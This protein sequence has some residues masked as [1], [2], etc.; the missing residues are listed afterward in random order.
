M[1]Y[2]FI[3]LLSSIGLV[4]KTNSSEVFSIVIDCIVS[5]SVYKVA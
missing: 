4:G 1:Q 5:V 3:A 2:W